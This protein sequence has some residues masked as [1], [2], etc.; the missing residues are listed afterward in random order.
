MHYTFAILL[1]NCPV[2][3]CYLSEKQ[4]VF[5]VIFVSFPFIPRQQHGQIE[6]KSFI[7][8]FLLFLAK[9]CDVGVVRLRL[10]LGLRLIFVHQRNVIIPER[11]LQPWRAGR[12]D[13]LGHPPINIST[14]GRY[15]KH[16]LP[17]LRVFVGLFPQSLRQSPDLC[18][19]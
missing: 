15:G 5:T 11:T 4:P 17:R 6:G 16:I 3:V 12:K 19:D 2:A 8:F 1:C 18:R 9:R 14:P 7:L 13:L 10:Q